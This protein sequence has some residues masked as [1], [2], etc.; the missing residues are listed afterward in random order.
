MHHA[1]SF[2]KAIITIGL[3]AMAAREFRRALP[4]IAA[5]NVIG[6]KRQLPFGSVT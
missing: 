2:R 5:L 4:K 6:C 3:K 1:P